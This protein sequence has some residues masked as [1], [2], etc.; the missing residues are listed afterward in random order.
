[1]AIRSLPQLADLSD[2]ETFDCPICLSKGRTVRLNAARILARL[3]LGHKA[4]FNVIVQEVEPFG[5]N[6]S[7]AQ[8]KYFCQRGPFHLMGRAKIDRRA[9]RDT[10][11]RFGPNAFDF[12]PFRRKKERGFNRFVQCD[13]GRMIAA[14]GV[15]AVATGPHLG[16]GFQKKRAPR[17]NAA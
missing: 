11:G 6:F 12:S 2:S 5:V 15:K 17:H 1:M 7:T 8:M 9:R 13:G 3:E 10:S 4:E 16:L 14:G